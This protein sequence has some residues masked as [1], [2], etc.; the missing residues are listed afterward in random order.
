VRIGSFNN[1]L[2][3]IILLYILRWGILYSFIEHGQIYASLIQLDYLRVFLDV[4]LQGLMLQISIPRARFSEFKQ[5][6]NIT[7]RVRLLNRLT[8]ETVV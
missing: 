4:I 3:C 1:A 5:L 7:L 8:C 2:H 6:I